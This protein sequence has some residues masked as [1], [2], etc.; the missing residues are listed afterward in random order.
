MGIPIYGLRKK[1]EKIS[2]KYIF[3]PFLTGFLGK[4][5]WEKLIGSCMS[6]FI[7]VAQL[8]SSQKSWELSV[9]RG[10]MKK[11]QGMLNP[12]RQENKVP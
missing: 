1:T 4:I 3:L 11:K 6:S 9:G 7:E 10:K 12:L 8:E 2:L 5:P